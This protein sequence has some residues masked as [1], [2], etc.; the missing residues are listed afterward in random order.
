MLLKLLK[1]DFRKS[2]RFGVPV[3]IAAL[4][5]ALLGCG[6]AYLL[7]RSIADGTSFNMPPQGIVGST[8]AAS[9]IGGLVLVMIALAAVGAVMSV[10]LLVQYYKNTVSDEA[11]LTY[12]LPVNNAEIIAS[13][14]INAVVWSLLMG[15]ALVISGL[16]IILTGISAAGMTEEIFAD[17]GEMLKLI[18]SALPTGTT[19][20]FIIM[21]AVSYVSTFMQAFMAITFGSIIAKRH[22]ALAGVAM[23][24]GVSFIM[25]AIMSL[26]RL[27]LTGGLSGRSA[28]DTLFFLSDAY[29]IICTVIF[30]LLGVGYFFATKYM[31]DKKLNLD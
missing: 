26:V 29:L 3:I 10:L 7:C 18:R 17:L 30:I 24:F 16:A 4:A 1:Y 25:N 20:L 31:M 22:K 12:T 11:Y 15:A 2:A 21:S 6:N 8:I 28:V 9:A 14:L 19:I 23:V 5:F 13:A 27:S